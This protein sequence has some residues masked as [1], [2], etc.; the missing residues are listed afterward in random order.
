M[1]FLSGCGNG[2]NTELRHQSEL[3]HEGMSFTE[4]T[5]PQLLEH[6]IVFLELDPYMFGS[7]Y[8]KKA[9]IRCIKNLPFNEAQSQRLQRVVLQ[10]L[11]KFD[12]PEFRAYCRLAGALHTPEFDVRI[13]ERLQSPD[14]GTRRRAQE[15]VDYLER[16][17]QF[18]A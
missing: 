14:P 15:L 16:R 5:N 3:L 18:R 17:G 12:R 6:A 8:A 4:V 13:R 9:I 1:L 11:D 7:G 10:A 2:Y